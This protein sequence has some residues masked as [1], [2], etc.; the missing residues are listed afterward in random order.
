[1]KIFFAILL[2]CAVSYTAEAQLNNGATAPNW[3]MT[4]I[5]GASHTL[6]DDLNL[7]KAVVLDFS[8]AYCPT[9]WGYHNTHALKDFYT[10]R[11]PNAALPQANVY[12][13]ELLASNTTGCLYGPGGGG[14][15]YQ[16]CNG[17]S[18]GNWVAGTPYPIIDNSSQNTPYNINY[19]P[20]V[21]M[22]CPNKTVYL[23]GQ[24]TA[25]EL[26]NSMQTFCG[27]TPGGT[28][29]APLTY[30]SNSVNNPC[31]GDKK[32]SISL[33]ITG[34]TPPY[35]YL[36]NN[37]A[38]SASINTLAAGSYQAT[39]TD[40]QNK[41]LIT[42]AINITQATPI[43]V[44]S[45]VK[46][47][48]KCGTP[49]TIDL[50]VA[51]GT[52]AYAYQWSSNTPLVFTSA[53]TYSTTVTDA[54]GCVVTKTST[55]TGYDNQPT[56]TINPPNTLTCIVKE[57]YLDATVLPQSN[58]YT[59]TWTSANGGNIVSQTQQNALVN[60]K[61]SYT[62]K[63][64][65]SRSKCSATSLIV[66]T[67]DK[68]LPTISFSPNIQT[69]LTCK[70]PEL[71]LVPTITNAGNTPVF[72]WTGSTSV[73]GQ[74]T[75]SAIINTSGAYQLD[76]SNS[77]N[78][79]HASST[80]VNITEDKL[81]PSITFLPNTATLLTCKTLELTLVPTI[82]NAGNTPVFHWTGS[83]SVAGQN[84]ASAIINTSGAYQLDVS[85][86]TN[87][88]HASSNIVN[89][90]EDKL[91]PSITFLPNTATL[92]TCKTPEL[93]LVPTITNAGNTPVFHWTGSTSVVGQNTASATVNSA[94]TYQLEI[95]NPVN[96]CNASN[97]IVINEAIKPSVTLQST[98]LHCFGDKTGF[99][100][101]NTG[102]TKGPITY[103]WSNG[104]TTI[105]AH[106]L[107]A[108]TYTV[109]ITDAYGCTASNHAVV[110]EP[111]P[112]TTLLEKIVDAVGTTPTGSINLSVSG[113]IAPYTYQWTKANVTIGTEKNLTNVPAGNYSLLVTD[114]NGCTLYSA[115]FTIKSLTGIEEVSSLTY[116]KCS[117]NP[118][119]S[120]LN[121]SLQLI[122][123]QLVSVVLLDALGK[124]IETKPAISTSVYDTQFE[125]SNLPAAV[126]FLRI[127]VDKKQWVE[128]I[129][130]F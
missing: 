74:N 20:T 34:G 100:L 17:S 40:S 29:V 116:F 64:T 58:F 110:T 88:C 30:Q 50:T 109:T 121:V 126:Y 118:T 120:N 24:Q 94:G 33:S 55:M 98:S 119:S 4:D 47:Y 107:V 12:F 22:V 49:G 68:I 25:A 19:Y 92:L 79:C 41:T 101:I 96:G 43:T 57:A 85:N 82:T 37:A 78:G 70:T 90:T 45:T 83:T 54:L 71:T 6:Y 38:T 113:G 76:V 9:C 39:I 59:S 80:I 2:C 7:G 69:L 114:A 105:N 3:T 60:A 72:H 91:T 61:G 15:P 8:A 21:Y 63:V 106:N 99:I 48:E 44:N 103:Q 128:K 84:T 130:K 124:I 127:A 1:M 28:S 87:G 115:I 97:S 14:T 86:P 62:Y 23:V 95:S 53:G 27:I 77:T 67:E 93:T 108:G 117:P 36:W 122:E 123:P 18:A 125:V 35:S 42:S 26:D 81:T 66:V 73:A 112:L 11:G 89:I 65:D 52:G 13:I 56:A 51:G 31:F 32:G 75:A 10:A 46:P 104:E 111:S 5:N 102:D 16:A 129:V